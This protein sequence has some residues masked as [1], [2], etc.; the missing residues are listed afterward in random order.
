MQSV[1]HYGRNDQSGILQK[2]SSAQLAD[3]FR[4]MVAQYPY[5]EHRRESGSVSPEESAEDFRNAIISH[6]RDNGTPESVA[7]IETL[8]PDFPELDWLKRTV[9]IARNVEL[10]KTWIPPTPEDVVQLISNPKKRL[11]RSADELMEVLIETLHRFEEKLQGEPPASPALWNEEKKGKTLERRW[12]KDENDF[13]DQITIY[14]KEQLENRGIILNREV[15]IRRGRGR[16][17]IHVDAVTLERSGE[18]RR[19]AKVI[20]EVK[21]CWHSKLKTA[22]ENQ[23]VKKYL[24]TADCRHGIYLVGWFYCAICVPIGGPLE[25]L[26]QGDDYGIHAAQDYFNSQ[27]AALSKEG[28]R[29]QAVVLDTGLHDL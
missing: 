28:I 12:H 26:V 15:E 18:Q 10:R 22:M 19:R 23:L 21:G 2:L 25:R 9:L 1:A 20:I 11:V 7:A 3:L 13:A 29:V 6:L 27:A 14:L 16:T 8:I 5:R 24:T 17:D 4:W